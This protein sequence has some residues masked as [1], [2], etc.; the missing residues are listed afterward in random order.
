MKLSIRGCEDAR[1]QASTH[2]HK[3][4]KMRGYKQ[5][6]RIKHAVTSRLHIGY[7]NLLHTNLYT[8]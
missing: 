7:Y 1:V 4:I 8:L 3:D 2:K 6:N 5:V